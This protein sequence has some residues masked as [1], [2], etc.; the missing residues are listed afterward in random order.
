MHFSWGDRVWHIKRNILM[1]EDLYLKNKTKQQHQN[2]TTTKTIIP[3]SISSSLFNSL[4]SVWGQ[5]SQA[6]YL[7]YQKTCFKPQGTELLFSL[8]VIAFSVIANTFLKA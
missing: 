5:I 6:G 4:F 2:K 7:K 3:Q 1:I 8:G